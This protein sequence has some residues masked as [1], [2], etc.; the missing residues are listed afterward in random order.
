MER[1]VSSL[2][3]NR[4][5]FLQFSSAVAGTAEFC[6]PWRISP[7][8]KRGLPLRQFLEGR[9]FLAQTDVSGQRRNLWEL[10]HEFR[11]YYVMKGI[12]TRVKNLTLG[13]R[14]LPHDPG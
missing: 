9:F 11:Q 2:G 7:G 6:S 3:L 12:N 14:R 4:S 8:S 1:P 10:K 5:F 13:K